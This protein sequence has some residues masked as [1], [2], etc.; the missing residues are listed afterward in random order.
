MATIKLIPIEQ[1]F[2]S[3]VDR[4][5]PNECWE[6]LASR[7]KGYGQM[8]A[9]RRG[10]KPLIA[11]RVSWEIAHGKIP[12]G[13]YVCHHCDNPPCVNPQHLFLGT[14]QDNFRDRY[15]KGRYPRGDRHPTTKISDGLALQIRE[16]IK[17]GEE[18][19]AIARR[20]GISETSVSVIKNGRKR[21]RHLEPPRPDT[22]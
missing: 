14:L 11:S 2:W 18:Q 12:N 16:A 4:R 17:N 1:R 5:G 3:K 21:W 15:R 7:N 10:D 13:L 8:S 22:R 19:Q 6:W 20:L 9:G